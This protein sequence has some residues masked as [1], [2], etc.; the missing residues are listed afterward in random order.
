MSAP[1]KSSKEHG[2]NFAMVCGVWFVVRGCWDRGVEVP[3]P[4]LRI[5]EF[6]GCVTC[7]ILHKIYFTTRLQTD[8]RGASANVISC[9]LCGTCGQMAA[10]AA[11]SEG[12]ELLAT[13]EM[14]A[15]AWDTLL[16][17]LESKAVPAPQFPT[18]ASW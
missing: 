13:E 6:V 1:A 3:S 18:D 8:R 4:R 7:G 15:Y 9:L 2:T 17:T 14:C 12:A 16:A 11:S 10:A 5:L